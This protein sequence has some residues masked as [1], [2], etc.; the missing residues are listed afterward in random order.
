MAIQNIQ[1]GLFLAIKEYKVSGTAIFVNIKKAAFAGA[2]LWVLIFFYVSALM[3]VLK[4]QIPSTTYYLINIP[5]F[6]IL[7]SIASYFYFKGEKAG[8]KSG[9]FLGVI[10][11]LVGVVLDLAITIPLFI[12]DY[13]RLA[14]LQLSS[15]R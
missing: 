12:K 4:I 14:T 5:T 13:F 10:M 15:R 11:L 6:A 8:A 1:R 7:V 9:L 3:F 2:L